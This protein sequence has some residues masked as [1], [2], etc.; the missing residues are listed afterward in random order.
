MLGKIS[1]NSWLQIKERQVHMDVLNLNSVAWGNL[2]RMNAGITIPSKRKQSMTDII[3]DRKGLETN[4]T[5]A[6]KED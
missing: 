3:H 5:N 1:M 4:R 2:S 6:G